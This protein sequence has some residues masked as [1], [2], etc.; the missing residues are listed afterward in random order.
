MIGYLVATGIFQLRQLLKDT[1]EAETEALTRIAP[2]TGQEEFQSCVQR[3][4][5]SWMSCYS[6]LERVEVIKGVNIDEGRLVHFFLTGQETVKD[7]K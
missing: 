1:A 3:F 5:H 2:H 4:R 7:R 6:P